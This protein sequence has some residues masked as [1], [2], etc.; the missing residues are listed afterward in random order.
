M[1]MNRKAINVV[2][3]IVVEAERSTKERCFTVSSIKRFA[4]LM[5]R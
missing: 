4:I 1:F 3:I 2:A 5:F